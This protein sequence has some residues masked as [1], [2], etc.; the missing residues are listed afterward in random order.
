MR[1][2]PKSLHACSQRHGDHHENVLTSKG[3]YLKSETYFQPNIASVLLYPQRVLAAAINSFLKGELTRNKNIITSQYSLI[4][5]V[6]GSSRL[7][8]VNQVNLL[9]IYWCK[10]LV[11]CLLITSDIS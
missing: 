4:Y 9:G 1:V 5:I 8:K 10:K 3:H 11:Y 6:I 2:G 7:K